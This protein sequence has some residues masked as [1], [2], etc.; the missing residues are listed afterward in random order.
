M[1]RGLGSC[2]CGN[3]IVFYRVYTFDKIHSINHI[4]IPEKNIFIFSS[5]SFWKKKK[6]VIFA[7][8]LRK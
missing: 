3:D 5:K 1:H 6:V 8:A 2:L 4:A 7:T